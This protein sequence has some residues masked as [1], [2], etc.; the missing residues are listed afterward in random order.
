MMRDRNDIQV[1]LGGVLAAGALPESKGVDHDDVCLLDNSVTGTVGEF[2]PAVGGSDLDA[3]GQF[4]L[5]C[6]NLA[7][8]FLASEVSAV[9]RLGSDGNG[10][11]GVGVL[12]GDVGDGLEI[13]VEGL[14]NIG[15][16]RR[17]LVTLSLSDRFLLSLTRYRG[18]P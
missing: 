5:D 11:N 9:E 3:L 18:R 8:E 15:P 13:L 12:A 17:T 10:V 4:R 2:V 6:R 7:R 14:L 1:D 16:G